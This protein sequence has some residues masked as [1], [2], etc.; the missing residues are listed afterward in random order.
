MRFFLA[1]VALVAYFEKVL[2]EGRHLPVLKQV[3]LGER[4]LAQPRVAAV[5]VQLLLG[6]KACAS[7]SRVLVKSEVVRV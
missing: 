7:I 6:E 4:D 5:A 1:G 2:I 3:G